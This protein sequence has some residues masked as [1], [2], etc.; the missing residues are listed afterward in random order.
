MRLII[1]VNAKLVGLAFHITCCSAI[2][3]SVPTL[4]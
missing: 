1:T 4:W 3:R 2:Y